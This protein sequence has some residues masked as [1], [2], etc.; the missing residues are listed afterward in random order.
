MIVNQ[1]VRYHIWPLTSEMTLIFHK[2]VR[3][4]IPIHKY[5]VST[6][7]E[8][9]VQSLSMIE[10]KLQE[11]QI[12]VT[13][14]YSFKLFIIKIQVTHFYMS[15]ETVMYVFCKKNILNWRFNENIPLLWVFKIICRK[16]L[17]LVFCTSLRLNPKLKIP[18]FTI[19]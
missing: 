19:T 1:R 6:L 15:W 3:P 5:Q 14:M 11:D 12:K 7:N 9:G 10:G 8:V 13:Q 16:L 18:T 2:V 17:S 4:T